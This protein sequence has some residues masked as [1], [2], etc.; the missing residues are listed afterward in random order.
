L[1]ATKS[2]HLSPRARA[3]AKRIPPQ[4][5]WP[6]FFN[7]RVLVI[8]DSPLNQT[9]LKKL[10]TLFGFTVDLA[11]NG[12]EGID[13]L[14]IEAYDLIT[15][16]SQM[17]VMSGTETCQ[18]IKESEEFQ[19]IP[20]L[21]ITGDSAIDTELADKTLTKPIKRSILL[22]TLKSI[23]EQESSTVLRA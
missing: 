18:W 12:R 16:D 10:F 5:E 13:K 7:K 3:R 21:F 23:F 9:L 14:Q 20:V 11:S 19:N 8:D 6:Y 2:F 15:L 17:P 1:R 22:S 4:E